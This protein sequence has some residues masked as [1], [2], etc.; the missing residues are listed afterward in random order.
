MEKE[1]Q[2]KLVIPP[3]FCLVLLKE[4]RE[5]IESMNKFDF[6]GALEQNHKRS[7]DGSHW[8]EKERK[9]RARWVIL[10][11][12][13]ESKGNSEGSIVSVEEK[14]N[15]ATP[16][17]NRRIKVLFKNGDN[18]GSVPSD[19]DTVSGQ[20]SEDEEPEA[21]MFLEKD[22]I[23]KRKSKEKEGK[24]LVSQLD[25]LKVNEKLL[26]PIPSNTKPTKRHLSA[27]TYMLRM[28]SQMTTSQSW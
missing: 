13:F 24:S 11:S 21:H 23:P 3:K 12:D 27:V 1:G 18:P 17:R 2:I 6:K 22:P 8:L 7:R 4:M 5:N 10:D 9:S 15:L 20:S 25:K 26:P 28:M 19:T 16:N 14:F